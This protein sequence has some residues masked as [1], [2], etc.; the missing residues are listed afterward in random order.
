MRIVFVAAIIIIAFVAAFTLYFFFS[1]SQTTATMTLSGN[2]IATKSLNFFNEMRQSDGTYDYSMNCTDSKGCID[3][4]DYYQQTG[5]WPMLAYAGLYESAGNQQYLQQ[6]NTEAN[7]LMN[8]CNGTESSCTL[9]LVQM[10]EAYKLTKNPQYFSFITSLG[11]ILLSDNSRTDVMSAGIEAREF[12]LLY[13]LTKNQTYLN[14]AYARL[15]KSK[16]AWNVSVDEVNQ[17]ALKTP[18]YTLYR[19]A[20]WT[21]L[22]E[23]EIA[24]VNQDTQAQQNVISFLDSANITTQFRRMRQ[25]TA[26][27]PCIET[28]QNIYQLTG[29]SKYLDQ[30]KTSMQYIVTYRWDPNIQIAKKYNGDGGYLIDL[31]NGNNLKTVTDA[32]YMIYLLS[33]MPNE[34]F[35]IL[36]WN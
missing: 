21:E 32:G 10:I 16:A 9:V 28:F 26:I 19:F 36:R 12:A 33:K 29:D 5:A 3:N 17:P 7:N 35:T 8:S 15:A 25:L 22:A 11:N 23:S 31:Y 24:R 13:E 27:Q 1:A 2:G 34:Q 14:E 4:Q 18:T 6:L 30:A 20:C